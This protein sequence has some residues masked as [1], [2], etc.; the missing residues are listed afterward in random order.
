MF[1]RLFYFV[2]GSVM[3]IIIMQPYVF[4]KIKIDIEN[5]IYPIL[6]CPTESISNL[7]ERFIF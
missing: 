2:L 7:D 1:T 4:D 3:T 6:E 5:I